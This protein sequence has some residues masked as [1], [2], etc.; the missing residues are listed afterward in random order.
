MDR[1]AA[2]GCT[3]VWRIASHEATDYANHRWPF[4][5][6]IQSRVRSIVLADAQ[7]GAVVHMSESWQFLAFGRLGGGRSHEAFR[8]YYSGIAAHEATLA[9]SKVVA[10][11]AADTY[12]SRAGSLARFCAHVALGGLQGVI[13]EMLASQGE[14]GVSFTFSVALSTG[15]GS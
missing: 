5:G 14:E 3:I 6:T 13:Q 9:G 10:V 2:D 8:R 12:C 15:T 4:D 11:S 7:D 1:L